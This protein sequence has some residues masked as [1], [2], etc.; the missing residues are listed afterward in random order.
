MRRLF[1]LCV[2]SIVGLLLV[3]TSGAAQ[4]YQQRS[5][6]SP[7]TPP[8]VNHLSLHSDPQR[9]SPQHS[10]PGIT[11][12]QTTPPNK[13]VVVSPAPSVVPRQPSANG[14]H[15]NQGS[16]QSWLFWGTGY[17]LIWTGAYMP[18]FGPYYPAYPYFVP[19]SFNNLG[20]AVVPRDWDRARNDPADKSRPKVPRVSNAE[21]KAKAGKFIG[22]GDGNF[23]KQK[24]SAAIERYRTA[25]E[26][27][28]DLA[29]P[30]FR[31][32]YALVA[33]G[34]YE[35]AAKAFRRAL[36]IRPDWSDSA[37]RLDQ[38][39]GADQLAKTT[40]LE[41][42]AKAIEANP[43][44]SEL[45]VALGVQ[46]YFDGQRDRAGVFLARAAQLGANEDKLLNDFLPKPGPAGAAVQPEKP[47]GKL[48]F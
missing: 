15:P 22:F 44:D 13:P 8:G 23:G 29:E 39:Y 33:L 26:M 3:S 35:N 42:L 12:R 41:S 30:Y 25:A 37:F 32:G 24:Y 38:I 27:A 31:Q 47:G 43:F 34:Q 28:P 1:G 18:A 4:F 6:A 21:T 17:P 10:T 7:A 19:Q 16:V 48:V 14:R 5:P 2:V 40:H 45:L 11:V 46:L 36:K 20:P 9:S